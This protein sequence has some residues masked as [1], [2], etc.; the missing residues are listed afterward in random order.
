MTNNA[1]IVELQQQIAFQEQ[2]VDTL[3]EVVSRQQKDLTRI[4]RTLSLLAQQMKNLQQ[5]ADA[6]QGGPEANEPPPH[7]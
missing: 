3:N 2:T 7:Y 6:G 4:E 5:A 1:D